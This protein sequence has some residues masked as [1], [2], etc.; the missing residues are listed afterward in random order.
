[1]LDGGG[2]DL[3]AHVLRAPMCSARR[4]GLV[5]L[6]AV[7]AGGEP[8]DEEAPSEHSQAVQVADGQDG[9][10]ETSG[11]YGVAGLFRPKARES[12]S[13]ADPLAWR[14]SDETRATTLDRLG[15]D[16][17]YAPGNPETIGKHAES[18]APR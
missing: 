7:L 5:L 9:P 17:A 18:C 16:D 1:M 14:E 3:I 13:F 6:G 15:G 11:E 2:F 10:F 8:Q 4:D 12:A